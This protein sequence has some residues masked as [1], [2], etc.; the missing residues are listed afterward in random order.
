MESLPKRA[1]AEERGKK[2]STLAQS[3]LDQR[4]AEQ[5]AAKLGTLHADPAQHMYALFV[6]SPK[7]SWTRLA[8]S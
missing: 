1:Y 4:E 6:I 7:E 3:P 8:M 2:Q 5:I